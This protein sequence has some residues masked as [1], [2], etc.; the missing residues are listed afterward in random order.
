M[1][2]GKLIVGNWKMNPQSTRDAAK[3]FKDIAKIARTVPKAS[4][5]IC[6]PSIYI[7]PLAA[8]KEKKV[9]LGAQDLFWE[10]DGAFT[11][12]VSAGM[13]ASIGA[14]MVIVGHSERRARG[15]SDE[16]A[17]RKVKAALA[18]KLTPILCVGE[19]TRGNEGEHVVSVTTQLTAAL[20][21]ISRVDASRVVVAYEPIWAIGKGAV[22]PATKEE[23][24]EMA[25]VIRRALTQLFGRTAAENIPIL[26]GGS[27]DEKNAKEF[28]FN[29][30]MDGLLVGRASLSVKS[31]STIIRVAA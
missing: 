21:G 23:G 14:K 29:A 15:E 1:K 22:R 7:A 6:S 31:F 11:G 13:L 9:I 12:E 25:I 4:V 26:Y 3:L 27:V 30:G 24:L 20:K 28:L 19:R 5:A 2:K 18:G 16:D 17:Q 8:L 10:K